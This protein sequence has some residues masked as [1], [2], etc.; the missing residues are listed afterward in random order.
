MLRG[1]RI[2]TCRNECEEEDLRPDVIDD[3]SLEFL[4]RERALEEG[5]FGYHDG[6]ASVRVQWCKK[7][8]VVA[9]EADELAF[10]PPS[11]SSPWQAITSCRAG[12]RPERRLYGAHHIL[13]FRW[14][15]QTGG[16]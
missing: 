12:P 10:I 2:L 3:S 15:L 9:K 8:G 1:E 5:I 7:E 4:P 16:V 6:C 13:A 11:K 14:D